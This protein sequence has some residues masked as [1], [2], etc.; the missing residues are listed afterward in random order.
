MWIKESSWKVT[1]AERVPEE[2]NTL[3]VKIL[4]ESK[5]ENR[6]TSME[7]LTRGKVE[8]WESQS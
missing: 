6:R 4:R 1:R 3:R 8:F 2:L 5:A 7:S